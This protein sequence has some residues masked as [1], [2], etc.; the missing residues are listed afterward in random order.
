MRLDPKHFNLFLGVCAVITAIAIFLFTILYV[1][2]QQETFREEIE[3]T[4]LSEWNMYHFASDD[5][6][7]IGQFKGS[8]VII[9]FWSTWS[10]MSMEINEEL[11]QIEQNTDD[12]VVIAAA[13]RDGDELVKEYMSSVPYNFVFV[14]GTTLYQ[15][16]MVPGLPSQLYVNRD[17]EIVDHLVGDDPENRE[18]KIQS[19]L[20]RY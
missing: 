11:H 17:G 7:S 18:Q 20:G 14:N 10:E 12:I 15:E 1:S 4:E 3:N 16:M 8:P 13:A 6:I 2:N 19:L 5:S 9:H